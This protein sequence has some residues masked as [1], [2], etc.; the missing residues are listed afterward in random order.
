M[1]KCLIEFRPQY[2]LK[3][4]NRNA[5]VSRLADVL[6]LDTGALFNLLLGTN[7]TQ[8]SWRSI[9]LCKMPERLSPYRSRPAPSSWGAPSTFFKLPFI[10]RLA[11]TLCNFNSL[12]NSQRA[13]RCDV[14]PRGLAT[15][16]I[17]L[18]AEGTMKTSTKWPEPA[19]ANQRQW[20]RQQRH[21]RC[22]CQLVKSLRRGRM[23]A[24][25]VCKF[26]TTIAHLEL[27]LY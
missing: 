7:I 20:A 5:S 16:Q 8:Q 15:T 17:L 27:F 9:S 24:Q 11:C 1:E 4:K 13:T 22:F 26:L 2:F 25:N 12:P 19:Y 21:Q 10:L 14:D 18:C 6:D 23:S 3:I